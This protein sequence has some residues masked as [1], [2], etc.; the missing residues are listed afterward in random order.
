MGVAYTCLCTVALPVSRREED[1]RCLGLSVP[2]PLGDNQKLDWPATEL[3]I[4]AGLNHDSFE[5]TDTS[6]RGRF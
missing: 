4:P 1:V 6:G 3:L 2:F 5:V